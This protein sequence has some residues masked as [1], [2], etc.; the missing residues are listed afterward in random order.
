[1]TISQA[2]YLRAG[3][4][5]RLAYAPSRLIMRSLAA[6]ERRIRARWRRRI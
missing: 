1:M 6:S 2:K 5:V 3:V 4:V